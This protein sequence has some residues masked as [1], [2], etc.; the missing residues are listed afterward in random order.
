MNRREL[1]ALTLAL[2]LA[3][4]SNRAAETP[5]DGIV[6]KGEVTWKGKSLKWGNFVLTD[7]NNKANGASADITDGH[8]TIIAERRLKPGKYKVM[9]F[10]GLRPEDNPETTGPVAGDQPNRE[11]LP[12]EHNERSNVMVEIKAQGANNLRYDLK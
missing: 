9:I 10:G 12:P 3:G 2:L 5:A 1:F 4:C 6:V 7:P 11:V 8:F